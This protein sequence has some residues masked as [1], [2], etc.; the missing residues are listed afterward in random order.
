MKKLLSVL[1]A[2]TLSSAV[3]VACGG[4]TED[5]TPNLTTTAPTTTTKAPETTTAPQAPETNEPT[6]DE[7][8]T[9]EPST[10]APAVDTTGATCINDIEGVDA[11]VYA[12][13]KPS[14]FGGPVGLIY[15]FEDKTTNVHT[16]MASTIADGGYA[17]VSIDGELFKIEQY[18]NGAPWFRMNVETPGATLISGVAYEIIVYVYNAE[19]T[20]VYYTKAETKTSAL[21][22]ENA[23][24]DRAPLNVE[25]PEGLTKVTADAASATAEGFTGQWGDGGTANLFDGN[26]TGTKIG[27]N[28][29]GTVTVTF[30]LSEAATVTYYTLYTGGDTATNANRNPVAWTLYGEVDGEWVELANVAASKTNVTGLEATNSTPYSYAVSN[31]KECVNYK[32][33]FTTD[34]AFQLNEM[35]LYVG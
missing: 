22:T 9:D 12:F 13:E 1:L 20:M 18:A 31:A 8:T 32:I 28:T 35:E 10:D 23:P 33:V 4:E 3:L 30:S 2:L 17:V 6:T 7:P 21:S 25:L 16:E 26:T 34:S 5:T 24:T 15:Y 11:R 29:S 14:E 27:G 19:D